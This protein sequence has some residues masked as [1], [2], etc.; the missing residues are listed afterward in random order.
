MLLLCS[1][2]LVVTSRIRVLNNITLGLSTQLIKTRCLPW[3]G[4]CIPAATGAITVPLQ[5]H[6]C[7]SMKHV[8]CNLTYEQE[9][10][11]AHGQAPI[12]SLDPRHQQRICTLVQPTV[13]AQ[14][15]QT[16][17]A[18]TLSNCLRQNHQMLC[19]LP[20]TC[21]LC[22]QLHITT[23]HLSVLTHG[24]HRS[25]SWH[26]AQSRVWLGDPAAAAIVSHRHKRAAGVVHLP[27]VTLPV[28]V[29]AA[30]CR[31]HRGMVQLAW[32]HQVPA[33]HTH[34]VEWRLLDGGNHHV[35][36]LNIPAAIYSTP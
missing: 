22:K 31:P 30:A 34:N 24:A 9:R 8:M 3:H 26:P 15:L 35:P 21:C 17:R 36:Q 10:R 7:E 19:S 28:Q 6:C 18:V 27:D 5:A 23:C 2:S 4:P 32:R 1:W 11:V 20:R 29:V 25:V 13:S 33:H 16:D 12:N 14:P